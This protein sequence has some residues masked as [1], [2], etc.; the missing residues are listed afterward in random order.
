MT[1]YN[2][3]KPLYMSS[4]WQMGGQEGQ[5][6]MGPVLF[7]ED[8]LVS[9]LIKEV[10]LGLGALGKDVW[11]GGVALTKVYVHQLDGDMEDP[12]QCNDMNVVTLLIYGLRLLL[13]EFLD[14]PYTPPHPGSAQ[15]TCFST[16]GTL[17]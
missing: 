8:I 6:W 3:S 12:G 4:T 1:I 9:R 11:F 17:R 13:K 14:P 5:W 15:R 10:H 2:H 16:A 7:I